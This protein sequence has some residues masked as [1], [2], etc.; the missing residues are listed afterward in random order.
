M[1]HLRRAGNKIVRTTRVVN[2]PVGVRRESLDH[3]RIY[4][5]AQPV[6]RCILGWDARAGEEEPKTRVDAA[7]RFELIL[8]NDVRGDAYAVEIHDM[9]RQLP[10]DQV[11]HHAPI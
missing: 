9:R 1:E 11:T 7:R 2:R 4:A 3:L 5:A 6:P 10:L 8:E